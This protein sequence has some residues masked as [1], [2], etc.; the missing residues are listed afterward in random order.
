MT[1]KPRAIEAELKEALRT[2]PAILVTGS[3]QAGKTTLLRKMGIL[4]PLEAPLSIAREIPAIP[5]HKIFD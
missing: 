1:Y 2:F 3:R 4:A 5:W